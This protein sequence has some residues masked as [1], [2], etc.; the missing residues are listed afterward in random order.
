MQDQQPNPN[1]NQDNQS[2]TQDGRGYVSNEMADFSYL[3]G[4]IMDYYYAK[5]TPEDGEEWKNPIDHVDEDV[6]EHVKQAFIAKL[7]KHQA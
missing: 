3:M 5:E 4:I 1:V 6:D 7:K 2:E